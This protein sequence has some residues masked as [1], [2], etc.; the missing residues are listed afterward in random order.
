MSDT[1]RLAAVVEAARALVASEASRYDG[2]IDTDEWIAANRAAMDALTAAVNALDAPEATT[3]QRPVIA[4][5][6]PSDFD[7]CHRRC[8]TAGVH[9]LEWGGCE[10]APEPP[11]PTPVL[12]VV[13]IADDGHRSLRYEP[14]TWEQTAGMLYPDTEVAT[15]IRADERAKV[16]AELLALQSTWLGD[17]PWDIVQAIADRIAPDP[18]ETT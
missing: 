8:R 1:T 11:K 12:P 2:S 14:I 10:H 15:L 7:G 3:P 16:R 9:S 4:A 5:E 6:Q 18:K 17:D 13:F